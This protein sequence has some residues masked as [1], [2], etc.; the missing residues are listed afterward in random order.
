MAETKAKAFRA[1]EKTISRINTWMENNGITRT[2]NNY[3]NLRM[4]FQRIKDRYRK[5]AGINISRGYKHE[6]H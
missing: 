6:R 4:K 5:S 1:D 3:E 2:G